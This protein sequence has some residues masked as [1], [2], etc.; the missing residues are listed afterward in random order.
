MC[1][2][3]QPMD[4]LACSALSS[5][6]RPHVLADILFSDTF[7]AKT[8]LEPVMTRPGWLINSLR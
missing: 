6:V 1:V 4:A 8:T 3:T 2:L 5:G 7:A